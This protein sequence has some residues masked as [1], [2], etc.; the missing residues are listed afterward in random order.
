MIALGCLWPQELL[1]LQT[2]SVCLLHELGHGIVMLL[3]RAG[4]QRICFCA[5]GVR[6]CTGSR[7]LPVSRLIPVYLS[8]PAVNFAAALL[9]WRIMPETAALH[10]C[11]GC[12]NL[13]PYRVLD[14]GAVLRC[15]LEQH[16][17]AQH[18]LTVC[19]MVLSAALLAIL[20]VLHLKNP[21]LYLM[22][23]YLSVEEIRG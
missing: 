9:L 15:L 11:M 20:V 14:G 10:L 4:L 16:T 18:V 7:L 17:V 21:V 2:F 22:I 1:L 6:L 23:L 12:F 3:T 19:C 5:S 8:G 13:L